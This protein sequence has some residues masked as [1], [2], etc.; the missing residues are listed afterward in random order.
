M[1]QLW[2]VLRRRWALACAALA[3]LCVIGF[4]AWRI[5]QSPE[6]DEEAFRLRFSAPSSGEA[7][8]VALYQ[9]LGAQVAAGHEVELLLNGKVFDA[10]VQRIAGAKSSIHIGMYIWEKGAASDRVVSAL[11]ERAK[12]GVA[13]RILVDDVGSPDFS[14]TVAP[15]LRLAGCEVR[16]FRPISGDHK[17]ARSHRKLVIVDGTAAITGGFG[18]R[19]NWLGDGVHGEAWRDTNVA[20]V[21]PA[22]GSAQQ[23]FAENWQEAGGQLLPA[24][25]FPMLGSGNLGTGGPTPGV[26]AAFVA[27]SQSVVTRAERLTQLLISA[28]TRRLWIANAYFVPPEGV[29]ELI[30]QKARAG[31]DVRILAPYKNSDSKTAFGAQHTEFGA[32]AEAGVK[33]WEYTPSMMHAKTMLV[34]DELAQVGSINLEPLSLNELEEDALVVE[35]AEFSR[36]LGEAFTA[37]CARSKPY[38]K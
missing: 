9:S 11:V 5:T 26:R 8:A 35:D 20:F 24:N 37:D 4:G 14:K 3:M 21:G 25:A 29:L 15:A 27:S 1:M 12:A 38:S 13:C 17:L 22:V 32:L 23:A 2:A 34:D 30:K 10:V 33:I 6:P 18:I 31:V 7:F 36:Q 28:A 19:D 16:V